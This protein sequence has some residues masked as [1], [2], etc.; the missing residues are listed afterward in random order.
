VTEA[1][2]LVHAGDYSVEELREAAFGGGGRVAR[3]LALALLGRKQYPEKVRDLAKVLHDEKEVPRLRMM[4]AQAL[5]EVGTPAA[6]RALERGLEAKNGVALRGVAHALARVGAKRHV[7]PLEALAKRPG[8]VG[9]AASRSLD[10]LATRVGTP[11]ARTVAGAALR[12]ERAQPGAPIEVGG[13]RAG[14]A[15]AAAAAVR[16]R[17][18]ARAGATS[19]HC[20]DRHVMF[21]FGEDTLKQGVAALG[22]RGEVG[23]VTEARTVEATGW[24]QR[25]RVLVEPGARGAFDVLVTTEDGRPVLRGRGQVRGNEATYELAA[26][27]APGAVP[28]HLSGRFDGRRLKVEQA[29]SGT[30]GRP[31]KTPLELRRR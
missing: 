7:A 20:G 19:F 25:Y 29:R 16:G 10:V 27:D 24:E 5:G 18:L 31:A 6:V 8:P 14:E 1:N 4:A 22:K 12:A 26:V 30:R 15:S 21:L 17:K 2:D 3:P 28:L 11:R 13:A 9:K 23:V